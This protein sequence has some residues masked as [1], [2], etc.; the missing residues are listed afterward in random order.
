[1]SG[2]QSLVGEATSTTGVYGVGGGWMFWAASVWASKA[3]A[4]ARSPPMSGSGADTVFVAARGS[5]ATGS[6]GLVQVKGILKASQ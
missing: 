4:A 5:S 2:S 6:A 1:M 3:M